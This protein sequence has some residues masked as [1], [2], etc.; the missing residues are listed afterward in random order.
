MDGSVTGLDIVLSLDE[1]RTY[2]EKYRYT[3]S[4]RTLTR[5]AVDRRVPFHRAPGAHGGWFIWKAKLDAAFN[6]LES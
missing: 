4:L 6:I 3:Y 2:L 1:A 5:M